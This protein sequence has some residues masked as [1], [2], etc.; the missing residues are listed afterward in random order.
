MS[1]F[2]QRCFTGALEIKGGAGLGLGG[3]SQQKEGFQAPLSS[4][5]LTE[6]LLHIIKLKCWEKRWLD[7]AEAVRGGGLEAG[8]SRPPQVTT[9]V[10]DRFQVKLSSPGLNLLLH[11][12]ELNTLESSQRRSV[13]MRLTIRSLDFLTSSEAGTPDLLTDLSPDQP[14]A[15]RR[16]AE[17]FELWPGSL[18]LAL[19]FFV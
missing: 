15:C 19:F 10:R 13:V 9:A 4:S 12:E 14:L 17:V 6:A 16:A 7:A 5:S 8:T 3:F 1:T 11:P 18:T 2:Q